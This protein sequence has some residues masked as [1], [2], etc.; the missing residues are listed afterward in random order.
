MKYLG[1]PSCNDVLNSVIWRKKFLAQALTPPIDANVLALFRELV[2]RLIFIIQTVCY[3]SEGHHL[4]LIF[5]KKKK[6][7]L[8][9]ELY[10]FKHKIKR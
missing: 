1:L 8:K 9:L 10:Q 6:K 3:S 7:K 5:V 4:A 2:V